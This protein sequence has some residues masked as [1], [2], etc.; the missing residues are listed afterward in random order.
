M[1]TLSFHAAKQIATSDFQRTF[2]SFGLQV[3]RGHLIW[4]KFTLNSSF[5]SLSYAA[6]LA[7]HFNALYNHS[8]PFIKC[9]D[10]P[11][12]LVSKLADSNSQPRL[13]SGQIPAHQSHLLMYYPCLKCPCLS[14]IWAVIIYELV[15]YDAWTAPPASRCE[16]CHLDAAEEP[17]MRYHL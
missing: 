11:Q 2:Y 4:V 1:K 15:F 17:L 3:V 7:L 14:I 12:A 10:C 8:K 5:Y 9:H 6:R 16:S 13:I